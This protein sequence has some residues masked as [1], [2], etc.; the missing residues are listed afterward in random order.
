M[1]SKQRIV[2]IGIILL[3]LLLTWLNISRLTPENSNYKIYEHALNEYN[4]NNFSEA[5]HTFGKVSRFSNLKAA[6][7]YRQ[8]LCAGKLGDAKTEISKYRDIIW[9]CPHSILTVRAKYLSAQKFYDDNKFNKAKKEFNNIVSRYPKSDYAVAAQYYLGSIEAD[10][11]LRIKNNKKKIKVQNIAI[12]HFKIYLKEAPTG[13]FAISCVQK[14]TALNRK[15]TNE[16][17]LLIAKVYQDNQDW[18]SAEKYLKF[19]NLSLSWPYFVQNAYAEKNYPKVKYYTEQGLMGKGSDE[20]L[21]NEDSD[22]KSESKSIY[23]AIDIYVKMSNSPQSAISYLLSISK[24]SKGYDYLLYKNCNNMPV[25]TQTACYNSLFYKYPDGQ[26]AADSL[27][28]IFYSK[29]KSRDYYTAKKLGRKHLSKFPRANSSP[30]VMF[31]LGKVSERSKNYEDARS[32]YKAVMKLFPDDYYAYRSFLNL[33]RF[34][35]FQVGRLKSKPIEFPYKNS[36]YGLITDLAKVKDYG[37]INQLCKDDDFIQSWLQYLEGNFSTSA[38]LARDAM[39]K[40]SR[41]P[42]SGDL[43]WRLV[44]PVHYYDLIE[45][46]ANLWN[47]DPIL[48][49]AIIREE[50]YFNP[51]VQSPVGAIGLMQLMPFTAREASAAAGIASPGQNSLL[52]PNYN[53]ELGNIYYSR[54]KRALLNKDFLAVL[55]YNGGIG[56]VSKWK[57]NLN[58]FD[59]DDLVEQIPYPETQNYLKK[60][61]RSY[62]NYLKIYTSIDF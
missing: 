57:E 56:S 11:S 14:W 43:R 29:I 39:E 40:L 41:K 20:V 58:Y 53:I 12:E 2:L 23:D 13:R 19:T 62:W 24:R 52:N 59:A 16:D 45:K 22:D 10:K 5:Y 61:F 48:I 60:V 42:N 37:L 44:Y 21:I 17:S 50:S 25:G 4:N 7:L 3:T 18:A 6:A 30:K 36:S 9:G 1:I 47:N 51:H 28:N 32:Y 15:L 54:L 35:H 46:Y 31:W 27:A 55:A 49:L 38:R 26:F 34:K 8:A 33:N